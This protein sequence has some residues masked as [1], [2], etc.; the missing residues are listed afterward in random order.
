MS[1]IAGAARIMPGVAETLRSARRLEGFASLAELRTLVEK[2]DWVTEGNLEDFRRGCDSVRLAQLA[3]LLAAADAGEAWVPDRAAILGWNGSGCVAE[4][5]R[6]WQD[7]LANGRDLGRGSLFVATLA[8][9]PACEAAITLGA[10][11]SCCYVKG[12]ASTCELVKLCSETLTMA[13]EIGKARATAL[14]FAPGAGPDYPE[15]ANLEQ[16]FGEMRNRKWK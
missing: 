5:H 14:V 10:H 11:G 7:F 8:S 12:A 3:A 13:I 1:I 16:L 9:T 2:A 15:C 6:Y 4:N